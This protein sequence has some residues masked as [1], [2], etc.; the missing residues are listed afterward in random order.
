[1]K[2]KHFVFLKAAVKEW[3]DML[4]LENMY[5]KTDKTQ[6]KQKTKL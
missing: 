1:M 2:V 4:Q 5:V 6:Q 3:K